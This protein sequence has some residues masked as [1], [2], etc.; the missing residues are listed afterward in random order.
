MSYLPYHNVLNYPINLSDVQLFEKNSFLS[1]NIY[2]LEKDKIFPYYVSQHTSRKSFHVN[3][4]LYKNH[5][6]AICNL[7]SFISQNVKVNRRKTFVCRFCLAYFVNYEHFQQHLKLCKKDGQQYNINVSK[8][9]YFNNYKS[10]LESPFVV[11]CDMETIIEEEQIV[12]EGKVITSRNHVPISIGAKLICRVNNYFSSDLFIYTGKDCVDKFLVFLYYYVQQYV[13]NVTQKV[14]FPLLFSEKDHI[15]YEQQD[16][17]EMCH[18]KFDDNKIKKVKDHCHLSGKYRMALCSSC[19]FT[20]AKLQ[21][22][23]YVFFHGLSNYDSHFIIQKLHS[24]KEKQLSIIPKTSEK[25]LTFKIDNLHFKDSFQFLPES[26][27]KLACFLKDKGK[28]HFIYL[29]RFFSDPRLQPFIFRKGVFPYSYVKNESILLQTCLPKKE[30]FF[31]D[32]TKTHISEN[33]YKYAQ[34][35]WD[36]F[37]CK[38]LKDYM[39]IYLSIDC[40]LLADIFENFRSNSLKNYLLDPVYYFSAAHFTLDA[41]L[42]SSKITIE[43]MNDVNQYLFISQGIRGGLSMVVKRYS[44]ANNSFCSDYNPHQKPVFFVLFGL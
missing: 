43:I 19:N 34:E 20:H 23:V 11:Y 15:L 6:F 17:C 31:D 8:N 16:F 39:E 3:L 12:N 27:S 33:D 18:K 9:L 38:T 14:C 1:I 25:Y 37:K 44:K 26:L 21:K 7:S 2:G 13:Y 36:V 40:L 35:C 28:E 30:D 4:L 24:F 32:L 10:I 29:S 22:D 41:F 42:K 5:Y